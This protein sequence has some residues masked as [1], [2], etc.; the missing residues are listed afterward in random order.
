MK[1]L[2]AILAVMGVL[3][4]GTTQVALAQ[5]E[6]AATEQQAAAPAAE[7]VEAAAPAEEA[8]VAEEGGGIHKELKIKFIEGS[9]FF[10]S[11]IAI[12]FV[13]GLA[14]CIERIIYL[15]LS[16]INSKKFVAAIDAHP[17][18]GRPEFHIDMIFFEYDSVPLCMEH[19]K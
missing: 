2:F 1:K 17:A 16:E 10:M 11:W 5:E 13:I 7:N 4:F 9:A 19:E 6:A 8:V 14:F 15:S 12:A 3:T 18:F